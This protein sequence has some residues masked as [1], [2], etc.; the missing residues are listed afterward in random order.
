MKKG[1]PFFKT[2]IDTTANLREGHSIETR[3]KQIIGTN[4][5]IPCEAGAYYQERADGVDP[6]CDVRTDRFEIAQ[7]AMGQVTKSHIAARK[8]NAEARSK[9]EEDLK[10]YV[11]NE[12][13]EVL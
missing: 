2:T 4:E 7:A 11:T 5:P 13:G 1:K 3:L 8:A 10:T 12:Q 9:G 6:A